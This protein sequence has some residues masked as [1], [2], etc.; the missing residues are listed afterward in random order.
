[1]EIIVTVKYL[2]DFK[3]YYVITYYSL[4]CS[5]TNFQSNI[6]NRIVGG[7][8]ANPHSW[9]AQILL[10]SRVYGSYGGSTYYVDSTCGGTL[11]NRFTVLT[12]AHCIL[13]KFQVQSTRCSNYYYGYCIYYSYV[14]VYVKHPF[15]SSQYTVYLGI[16]NQYEL[17]QPV[18]KMA[19]NKIIRVIII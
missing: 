9:P 2:L 10:K 17:T 3:N 8:E 12:A 18:V 11:I 16:H 1:M 5:K 19:V 13:T 14:D 4:D 7:I 6:G 15:D